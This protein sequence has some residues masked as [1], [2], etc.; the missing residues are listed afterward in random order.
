MHKPAAQPGSEASQPHGPEGR[1]C[2][3]TDSLVKTARPKMQT[4]NAL[5]SN[6]LFMWLFQLE[7]KRET[8]TLVNK[9]ICH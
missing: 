5:F 8:M 4:K 6:L 2:Q 1:S 9:Q 3:G 7:R